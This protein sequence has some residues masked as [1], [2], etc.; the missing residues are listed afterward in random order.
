[1]K[2]TTADVRRWLAKISSETYD[3]AE[4]RLA[5][6]ALALLVPSRRQDGKR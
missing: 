5:G 6:A 3:P 4:R 2:P 1:M